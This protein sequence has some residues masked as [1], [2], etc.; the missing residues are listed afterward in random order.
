MNPREICITIVVSKCLA[1]IVLSTFGSFGD[2]HP[3]LAVALGLKQRGHT[4]VIATS[5]IYRAKLEALDLAFAPVRPDVGELIGN[6]EFLEKLWHPRS[7]T[8]YLVREYLLPAIEAGY[9]DLLEICRGADLMLTHAIVF[10]APIVAEQLHL[11]WLSVALQP[12]LFLSAHDQPAL[13]PL[14][15][16][17]R[18]KPPPAV[19][20]ALFALSRR[21]SAPWGKPIR[22][23]RARAGLPPVQ[24]SV[25]FDSIFSPYGTLAWFSRHFS[26]PQP[27]WPSNVTI[28]GFPFFDQ[29]GP[30]DCDLTG[31]NAFLDAGE[32]PILFT[33]GS[34]ATFQA[35]SFYH[36][37]LGAI[38]DSNWRGILLV[39]R[40]GAKSLPSPLPPNVHV[41]EYAPYSEIMP[42]CAAIVHQ[43][44]IGT[45]AQAL[46]SGRPMIV[47]PWSHDQPDN[48][49]LVVR[50]GAGRTLP[51]GRY[52]ARL[53]RKE[54]SALLSEAS[55]A[56][57]AEAI[58]RAIV[59]E[60]AVAT[61]CDVIEKQLDNS[62]V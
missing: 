60:D 38:Q 4:A 26:Q 53:V 39:G 34:S 43:G 25:F 24:G 11:R 58:G 15:L 22:D 16:L 54:L 57:K 28:C 56:T 32:P 48:A 17:H 40:D 23:L 6:Q 13:T 3:Y 42:R 55:Y 52:S 45:T 2:L 61:A 51:R 19:Y 5:E 8:R 10:A 31:L 29:L 37:S 47:V 35:G 20:R 59:A 30:E 62:R 12:L 14:P 41:A 18:L 21:I 49:R 1:R 44:G 36:E 7:G 33:L 27:D 9:E 46:R 50:L